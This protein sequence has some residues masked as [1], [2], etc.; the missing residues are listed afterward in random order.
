MFDLFRSREKSVKILLGVLLL[1][2]AASML[3]YLVPGGFGNTGL[4]GDN[5]IAVVG[6]D[7]VTETDVQRQIAT[8]TRGQAN[9]PKGILAMYIPRIVEQLDVYKRQHG[10]QSVLK[11]VGREQS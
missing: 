3:I 6:N 1:L 2:V 8:I 11:A 7:K 10:R 5:V 9:L 4:T